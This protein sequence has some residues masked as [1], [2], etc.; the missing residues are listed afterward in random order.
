MTIKKLTRDEATTLLQST[1]NGIPIYISQAAAAA[2][3]GVSRQRIHQLTSHPEHSRSLGV[4][5]N[6]N[7]RIK[8]N[9]EKVMSFTGRNEYRGKRGPQKKSTKDSN[10]I[11]SI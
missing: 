7:G 5:T 4:I 1:E 10:A 11:A 2:L 6:D 8:L 3:L 9:L